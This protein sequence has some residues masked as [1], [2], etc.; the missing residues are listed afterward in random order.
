MHYSFFSTNPVKS[1][2]PFSSS[3]ISSSSSSSTARDIKSDENIFVQVM[4]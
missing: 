2:S 4:I 3:S 1:E